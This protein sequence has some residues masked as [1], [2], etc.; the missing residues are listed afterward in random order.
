MDTHTTAHAAYIAQLNSFELKVLKIATLQL[1]SSFSLEK[2]IG[3][4]EW[5]KKQ[6]LKTSVA[7]T[8]ANNLVA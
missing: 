1:E 8:D 3:F 5:L 7:L 2:S 6:E 4:Q